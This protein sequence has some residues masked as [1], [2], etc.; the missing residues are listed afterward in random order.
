MSL[1]K[2]SGIVAFHVR[3]SFRRAIVLSVTFL[4]CPFAMWVQES[5]ATDPI[6]PLGLAAENLNRVA[7]SAAQS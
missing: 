2:A 7:A 5:Q 4:A 6:A 3:Q 1:I